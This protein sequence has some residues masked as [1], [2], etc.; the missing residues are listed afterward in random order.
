[1]SLIS[2]S[3]SSEHLKFKWNDCIFGEIKSKLSWRLSLM[4]WSIVSSPNGKQLLRDSQSLVSSRGS[5]GESF[6]IKS[7]LLRLSNS[8]GEYLQMAQQI[9]DCS[10]TLVHFL[11]AYHLILCLH[12]W[13]V[14]HQVLILLIYLYKPPV[15]SGRCCIISEIWR[16]CEPYL[17]ILCRS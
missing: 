3:S 4:S 2:N 17:C 9:Q 6:L 5:V 12:Q 13:S 8:G 15:N 7:S 14:N 11:L 1:M 16:S 10:L